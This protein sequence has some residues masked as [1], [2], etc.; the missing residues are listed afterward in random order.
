MYISAIRL[1]EP[2]MLVGLTALSV[3]IMT[4]FVAPMLVGG[5]GDGL[6]AQDVVL[7]G[8]AGV[9]FH[10]RDVLVGGGV[11]DDLRSVLLEDRL[12]AHPVGDVADQRLCGQAG[13]LPA[14]FPLDVE[15]GVFRLLDEQQQ[16]RLELADLAAHLRADGPAGAGDQ[17]HL[18][19][20]EGPDQIEVELDDFAPEQ[21]VDIDVANLGDA[22]LAGSDVRDGGDR[23]EP[24]LC[25]FADLDDAA[26]LL[27][28]RRGHGDGDLFDVAIGADPWA[29]ARP[30]PARER[31]GCGCPV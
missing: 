29:T 27:P 19:P 30:F 14:Q 18:V 10:Q 24:D 28:R 20:G 1:D 5:I 31:R 12:H 23:A 6:R 17:D 3:L 11:D 4:K 22:E 7:D 2:M 16:L 13:E 25:A 8:L 9:E 21:V 15:E 26:Q